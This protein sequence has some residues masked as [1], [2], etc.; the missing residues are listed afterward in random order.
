[1]TAGSRPRNPGVLWY[2]AR[3]YGDFSLRL[4]FRDDAPESDARANSGLQVRFPAPRPPVPGC[5]MM[6][7]G[8]PQENGEAWI[9]VNCRHEVQINDSPDG[10]PFDPRRLCPRPVR[11]G[12]RRERGGT[13]RLTKRLRHERLP[14]RCPPAGHG[15]QRQP[16]P[17]YAR[18]S[19]VAL[20]PGGAPPILRDDVATHRNGTRACPARACGLVSAALA[21]RAVAPA[22][23]RVLCLLHARGAGTRASLGARL[24]G[25]GADARRAT[26]PGRGRGR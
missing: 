15:G 20:R 25:R 24:G 2:A 8:S 22:G 1:M 13:A 3:P 23:G 21:A 4:Q 10:P 12:A 18:G 7:N 16:F 19:H 6:F 9:A 11:W 14:G 17:L 26:H 5:P